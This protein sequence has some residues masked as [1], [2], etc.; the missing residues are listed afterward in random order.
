MVE[1]HC[2]QRFP[3][4]AIEVKTG[5][6]G[7]LEGTLSL[8][9]K[10]QADAAVVVIEWSDLDPRLGFRGSGGWALSL[11][12][13]IL[14]TCQGRFTRL[15]RGLESLGGKMPVALVPPTLLP[16][17]WG[18]TASWHCSL[19]ELELQKY[20]TAFLADA[21]R[22][23]GVSIIHPAH[24]A[25]VSPEAGRADTTMELRAGFP[26]T[27]GHASAVADQAIR[28]L[29][30][31][32]PKKGLITDLDETLWS[33]ILGEAGASNVSWSLGDHAQIHGLYQHMLRHLSEM[34]VLIG[35]ASKNEQA[36]VEQALLR[37]DL[38]APAQALFPVCANW[39]PK[40]AS[41]AEI[42][43]VW[44]IGPESVVFVDDSPME[45]DEVKAA[46]P[47]MTCLLFPTKRA[48]K[49]VE[50][51]DELRSL[52]GKGTV[53][54]EDALRGASI[55]A[56]AAMQTSAVGSA[57]GAF[58]RGLE[59]CVTFDC[60]KDPSNQRIPELINKT[61]QFNL[62]GVRTSTGEWLKQIQDENSLVVG[63]SYD[64]KFG[65]L[66]T[67]GALAGRR[68]KNELEVTSWVLSCRAFSRR[69]EDH[70]LD[71]VF[72]HHGIST[73]RLNFR[74]TERNEPLRRYLAGLGLELELEPGAGADVLLSPE[75]FYNQIGELPHRVRLQNE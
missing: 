59:G 37:E 1:A 43:R 17:P 31:P 22:I 73:V 61:N 54:R 3:N 75:Q 32:S 55:R 57:D 67:I 64:D 71:H 7:D 49:C 66:G 52:F 44:N 51:L 69:I 68:V 38:F 70:M 4:E 12:A 2:V 29:Y 5:L 34:G 60:R 41:V 30:P 24:L 18:H 15:L 56:N 36:V 45:L 13:D 28:L 53:Q 25:R 19:N 65:P 11:Q 42:L 63:V 21:A 26:Y 58:V 62:N 47:A 33:G 72:Q 40:S 50:L 27:I 6:Y 8:A 35:V 23:S 74:R 10:S 16:T 14:A 46:F 48:A 39:G 9:A 20:T